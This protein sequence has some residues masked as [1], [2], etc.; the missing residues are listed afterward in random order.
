MQSEFYIK[1]FSKLLTSLQNNFNDNHDSSRFGKEEVAEGV[2]LVARVYNSKAI[3]KRFLN[4]STYN[5][6]VHQTDQRIKELAPYYDRLAGMYE[7]LCDQASKDLLID[8][9]AYRVLGKKK[10]KLPVNNPNYWQNL[11]KCEEIEDK[12]SPIDARL[13]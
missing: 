2:S 6:L 7:L 11:Q 13:F 5:S 8:L 4:K 9:I 1:L 10:I 12:S 3:T